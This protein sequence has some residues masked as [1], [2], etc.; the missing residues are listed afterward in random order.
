MWAGG[1]AGGAGQL[2]IDASHS[3]SIYGSSQGVTPVSIKVGFYI[4]Y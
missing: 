4:K 2:Y 1:N 3:S